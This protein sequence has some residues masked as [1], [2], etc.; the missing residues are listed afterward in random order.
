[1]LEITS[2]KQGIVIDHIKAGQGVKLFNLL[3]LDKAD[4]TVALIM[5]AESEKMGKKDIIKIEKNIDVNL[6]VLALFGKQIT[7]N[8]IKDEEIVEKVEIKLPQTIENALTCKNP[9]CISNHERHVKTEFQLI[10]EEKQ[11]YTCVYCDHLYDLEEI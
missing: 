9:R 2:I 1:M 4:F 6:D 5:N 11:Q 8:I 3:N 10:N 7:A